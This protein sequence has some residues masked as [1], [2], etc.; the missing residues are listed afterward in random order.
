[1]APELWLEAIAIRLSCCIQALAPSLWAN[2]AAL[3]LQAFLHSC[4]AQSV[5]VLGIC[6][7]FQVIGKLFG[8]RLLANPGGRQKAV[9]TIETSPSFIGT[10]FSL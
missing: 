10:N 2:W 8:G 1:M 3:I 9:C 6:Y 7:G 4:I 5:N